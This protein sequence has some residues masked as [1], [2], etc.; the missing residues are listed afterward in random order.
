MKKHISACINCG[1]DNT[2]LTQVSSG[3]EAMLL[4]SDCFNLKYSNEAQNETCYTEEEK[5]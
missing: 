4:C 5:N 2:I 1:E 3:P